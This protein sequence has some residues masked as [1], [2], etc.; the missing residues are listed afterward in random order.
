MEDLGKIG[1]TFRHTAASFLAYGFFGSGTHFLGFRQ[2]AASV[3]A[4][5]VFVSGTRAYFRAQGVSL[6][7]GT[8]AG[9]AAMRPLLSGTRRV[10][11]LLSGTRRGSQADVVR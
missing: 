6:L 2:T 4:H 7:S 10:A 3:Q 5:G 9:R 1:F 11:S 8:R